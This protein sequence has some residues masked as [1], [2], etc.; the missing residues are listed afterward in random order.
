MTYEILNALALVS[1][2]AAGGAILGIVGFVIYAEFFDG[3]RF[4]SRD[5]LTDEEM[6]MIERDE[7]NTTHP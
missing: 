1:L 6:A 2:V 7:E 5:Y 4:S 3:T